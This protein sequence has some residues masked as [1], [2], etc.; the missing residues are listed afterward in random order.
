[1]SGTSGLPLP[2]RTRSRRGIRPRRLVASLAASWLLLLAA[3][4][5]V[6]AEADDAPLAR[7]EAFL[8]QGRLYPAE[9]AAREAIERNPEDASAQRLLGQILLRRGKLEESIAAL[10]RA[11]ELDA[12]LTG[13]DR[14]LADAWLLLGDDARACMA[15][16]R[17]LAEQ[18]DDAPAQLRR[19]QCAERLGDLDAA[20]TALMQASQDPGYAQLAFYQLG[21]L[22]ARA[23][24]RDAARDAF[25]R[26]VVLDPPSPLA[27]RA[28]AEAQALEQVERS[29]SLGAAAGL[30]FDDDVTRP[31]VDVATGEPDQAVQLELE[32]TWQPPLPQALPELG[33]ELGYGLLQRLYFDTPELDLQSHAMSASLGRP[34]GP[35]NASFSYL[36]S[37]NTLDG[38]RFLDLQD[39]RPAWGFAPTPTWYATFGPALQIKRFEQDPERDSLVAFL[40]T[41]QLFDL[42]GGAWGRYL[43]LGVDGEY[44]N[45]DDPEFDARGLTAQAAIHWSWVFGERVLPFDLRYRFRW[46]DYLHDTT[47][48]AAMDGEPAVTTQRRDVIHALRARTSYALYRFA[49]P[50]VGVS[51]DLEYEFEDSDSDLP[52]ADYT[53]NVVTLLLRFAR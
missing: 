12:S 38:D 20:E 32:A 41:L 43:L 45:A 1:M 46:R 9:R 44:E 2:I 42:S 24:K 19:A 25:E 22:R 11:R 48:Q 34:L 8:E 23:G 16:Q 14:S 13:V 30:V 47:L 26:A 10:S 35:G 36:Y 6:H 33:L 18:P 39:I 15:Y 4:A 5:P 21:L 52:S 53:R 31:E 50:G 29:W 40:G 49:S 28:W 27:G 3:W 51:L 7:A 17:A 37:L